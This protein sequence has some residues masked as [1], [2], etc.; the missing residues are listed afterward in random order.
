M[1]LFSGL[2]ELGLGK[3]EGLEIFKKEEKATVEK[4]EKVVSEEDLIY[5]KS[6]KCPVCDNE[7][8]STMVKVGKNKLVSQDYDLRP[9]YQ[10]LD[11]L[12][13]D[14]VMCPLCGYSALNKFFN[15]ITMRQI[16]AIKE[17]VTSSFKGAP[18]KVGVY[19]YDDAL[20]RH[21][22]SLMCAV[23]KNA[24]L[25][26]KAYICLKTAWIIRGKVE[27]LPEDTPNREEL[28]AKLK[29]EE[30]EFMANAYEGFMEAFSKE[31]FPMCGMDDITVTYLLADLAFEEG[32]YEA[33]LRNISTILTRKEAS[34]R[35]KE[36]ARM[37]KERIAEAV[38]KRQGLN[39]K[40]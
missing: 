39:N 19:T 34:D 12:K 27:T 1:N 5:S 40:Q 20:M 14:A 35:I 21:K 31:D 28:I 4:K 3:T 17:K 7:F 16:G 25:S 30:K 13:Y 2:E 38:K 29:K 8:V 32:K 6:F 26:E 10:L 15:S 24:K 22:L 9:R 33:A 18:E 36:K 37:L 23:I 11:A